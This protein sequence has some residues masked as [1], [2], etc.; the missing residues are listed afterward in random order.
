MHLRSGASIDVL[1]TG[2]TDLVVDI[3]GSGRPRPRLVVLRHRAP[4]HFGANFVNI[5]QGW[6]T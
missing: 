2:T 3:Y 5:V 4:L 6:V 1:V